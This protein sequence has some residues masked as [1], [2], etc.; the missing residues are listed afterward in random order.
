MGATIPW[1][2]FYQHSM[3]ILCSSK[4]ALISLAYKKVQILKVGHYFFSYVQLLHQT[5]CAS[6]FAPTGDIVPKPFSGQRLLKTIVV[7]KSTLSFFRNLSFTNAEVM[8]QAQMAVQVSLG[9]F[10]YNF[11]SNRDKRLLGKNTLPDQ[12][13]SNISEQKLS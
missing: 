13:F 12:W 6:T 3:D 8:D 9:T 4:L 1:G 2:Q 10:M 5:L 7:T 11:Y